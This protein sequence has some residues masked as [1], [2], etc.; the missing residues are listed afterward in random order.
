[1]LQR[2]GACLVYKEPRRAISVGYSGYID[3]LSDGK[4]TD[5]NYGL[6]TQQN[7]NRPLHS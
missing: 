3:G 4:K 1:M 5:E 7:S 6:F 2:F